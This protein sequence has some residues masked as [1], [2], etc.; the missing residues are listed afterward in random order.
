M[1]HEVIHAIS[2]ELHMGLSEED[3]CRFA[4]GMFASGARIPVIWDKVKRTPKKVK[5][6]ETDGKDQDAHDAGR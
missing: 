4:V 1:L 3:T 6:G 5:K 2:R